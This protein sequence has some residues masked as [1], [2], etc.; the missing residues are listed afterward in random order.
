MMNF[1]SAKVSP[2]VTL[3]AGIVA[4]TNAKFA[5]AGKA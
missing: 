5:N 2:A 1:V 4:I 3:T